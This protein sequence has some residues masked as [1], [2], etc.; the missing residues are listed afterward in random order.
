LQ[1]FAY[2]NYKLTTRQWHNITLLEPTA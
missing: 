2:K 1:K